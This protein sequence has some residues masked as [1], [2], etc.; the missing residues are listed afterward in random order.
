MKTL[1]ILDNSGGRE[2]T[3]APVP[4]ESGTSR[5]GLGV[6]MTLS[7]LVGVWGVACIVNGLAAAG[8]IQELGRGLIT[9]VM[10]I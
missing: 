7:G 5:L 1:E 4:Y 10:G 9:A 3:A 2:E 6:I 8:S